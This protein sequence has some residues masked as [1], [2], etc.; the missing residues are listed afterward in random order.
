MKNTRSICLVMVLLLLYAQLPGQ[1]SAEDWYEKGMNTSF[2]TLQLTYFSNAIKL[3][4]DLAD[5]YSARAAVKC[6]LG[7]YTDAIYDYD[8]AIRLDPQNAD[9]YYQRATCKF[10][11]DWYDDAITDFDHAI[12]LS[13]THAYAISAKGCALLMQGKPQEAMEWLDRALRLDAELQSAV[14]CKIEA[15]KQLNKNQNINP[16]ESKA[17]MVSEILKSSAQP[18]SQAS[19]NASDTTG[20][21][22]LTKET[23]L[24]EGPDH[25]T[26]VLLR[27]APGDQ[28]EVLE[29]TD[30]WWWK[31]QHK[32]KIGYAKAALLQAVR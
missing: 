32:G 29:K 27:F 9:T 31:V 25:T 4:P 23:S 15:L 22:R 18:K 12:R 11:L 14:N 7:E 21:H 13:P 10:I 24:R 26:R 2:P 5:A 19:K 20:T 16:I 17:I 6:D 1:N 8:Q 30:H 3:Q 28:V